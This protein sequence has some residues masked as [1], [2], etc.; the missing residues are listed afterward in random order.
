[1][2]EP[3]WKADLGDWVACYVGGSERT[4]AYAFRSL[5][6]HIDA[7]YQRGLIAGRSQQGYTTR[8]KKKEERCT[9]TDAA[10]AAGSTPASP[11]EGGG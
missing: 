2:P 8:R 10:G 5:L 1:M 11:T 6:P 7:A 3:D 9:P 4:L